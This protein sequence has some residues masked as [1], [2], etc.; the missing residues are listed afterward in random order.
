[1]IFK[2]LLI[3]LKKR[4]NNQ[5][6]KKIQFFNFLDIKIF[7]NWKKTRRK[8]SIIIVNKKLNWIGEQNLNVRLIRFKIQFTIIVWF[9]ISRL[10]KTTKT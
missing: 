7:V 6:L 5:F 2:D 8:E 9:K 10:M 1:M 4:L 3:L